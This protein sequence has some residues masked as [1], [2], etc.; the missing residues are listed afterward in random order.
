[1][2]KEGHCNQRE[3]AS[4]SA[5][6]GMMPRFVDRFHLIRRGR[7][8]A[9]AG[10]S[11]GDVAERELRPRATDLLVSDSDWWAVHWRRAV[12]DIAGIA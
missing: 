5:D 10:A 8:V 11:D 4:P 7:I 1:M 2:Y 6:E 9:T 12:R 3:K